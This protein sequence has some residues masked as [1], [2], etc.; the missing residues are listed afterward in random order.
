MQA[1]VGL[2]ED[3][4]VKGKLTGK[5]VFAGVARINSPRVHFV[6]FPLH[7]HITLIDLLP[8]I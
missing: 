7:L 4:V 8:V 3:R 5:F 2:K 6:S 1:V